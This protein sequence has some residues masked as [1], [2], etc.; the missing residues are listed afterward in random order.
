MFW[1]VPP[2]LWSLGK[3]VNLR[4]LLRVVPSWIVLS[5]IPLTAALYPSA[6][7]GAEMG[8]EPMTSTL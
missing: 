1:S 2:L 7:L 8:F 3:P 4:R 5:V 6:A